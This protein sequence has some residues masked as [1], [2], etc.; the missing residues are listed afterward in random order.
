VLAGVSVDD[1]VAAGWVPLRELKPSRAE[2]TVRGRL[3]RPVW[4]IPRV[5]FDARLVG[6]AIAAGAVLRRQRVSELRREPDRVGLDGEI[7]AAM[8][9]GADGAQSTVRS[10]LMSARTGRRAL[11]IRGYAPAPE[12]RRGL[13]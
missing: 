10:H 3:A 7:E 2:H 4:V 1:D 8:V 11:A 9:V 13:Q 12:S 5:V 6:R